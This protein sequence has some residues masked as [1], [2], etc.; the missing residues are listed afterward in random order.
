M[1]ADQMYVHLEHDLGEII[2]Q[3]WGQQIGVQY[4]LKLL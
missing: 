4:H 1:L 3:Y 2:I